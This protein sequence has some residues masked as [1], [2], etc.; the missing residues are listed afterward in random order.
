MMSE[1]IFWYWNSMIVSTARQ[2]CLLLEYTS[3]SV[4]Q[5]AMTKTCF[6]SEIV[7]CETTRR[8]F[9]PTASSLIYVLLD[10]LRQA[11]AHTVNLFLHQKT[12]K[13]RNY[14]SPE[15]QFVCESQS[16]K[17]F[18]SENLSGKCRPRNLSLINMLL[19]YNLCAREW[20]WW[21]DVYSRPNGVVKLPGTE[22][23][24]PYAWSPP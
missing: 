9:S 12:E 21:P 2:R 18:D 23:H 10:Y 11:G 5:Q 14:A 13:I 24:P 22:A 16:W 20:S 3:K 6:D 7:Y 15:S 19:S 8:A 17:C 1:S 4:W